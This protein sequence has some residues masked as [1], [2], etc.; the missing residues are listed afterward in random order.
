MSSSYI[1]LI[2]WKHII[3]IF[4]SIFDKILLSKTIY[5]TSQQL[6]YSHFYIII[7]YK[8][9]YITSHIFIL[10]SFL[11]LVIIYHCLC[12]YIYLNKIVLQSKKIKAIVANV[13][14]RLAFILFE[15][16]CMMFIS[17]VYHGNDKFSLNVDLKKNKAFVHSFKC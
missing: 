16:R 6:Y 13:I 2:C 17:N 14:T 5:R 8:L 7:I 15:L 12:A 10:P 11:N 4:V 9:G 1:N 3:I